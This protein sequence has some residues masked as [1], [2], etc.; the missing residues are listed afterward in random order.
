MTALRTLLIS[1]AVVAVLAFA[2]AAALARVCMDAYTE[3]EA[4]R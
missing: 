3:N 1:A 2:Y 4:N